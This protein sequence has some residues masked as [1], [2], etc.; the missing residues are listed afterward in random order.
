MRSLA[1]YE[2]SLLAPSTFHNRGEQFCFLLV[3]AI[4]IFARQFILGMLLQVQFTFRDEFVQGAQILAQSGIGL[5]EF[6]ARFW[7]TCEP[8]SVPP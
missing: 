6:P 8:A 1:S 2:E 5:R 7:G 4:K 3:G